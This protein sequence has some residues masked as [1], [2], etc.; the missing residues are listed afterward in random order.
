MT[1]EELEIGKCYTSHDDSLRKVIAK[2]L[3]WACVLLYSHNHCVCNVVFIKSDDEFIE[4]WEVD[5]DCA[6]IFDE[7][8]YSDDYTLKDYVE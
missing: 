3:D 8:R 2:G 7:L 6:Y 5:D 4:N 1:F